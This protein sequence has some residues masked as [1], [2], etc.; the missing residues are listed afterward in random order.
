MFKIR[1]LAP[2]LI[3]CVECYNLTKYI[4]HKVERVGA[5]NTGGLILN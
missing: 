5:C 2:D 3:T 4:E 1:P